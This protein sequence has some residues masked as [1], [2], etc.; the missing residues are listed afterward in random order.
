[1]PFI[2]ATGRNIATMAM[3]VAITARPISD[4]A[5]E[6]ASRGAI[7]SSICLWIFSMTIMASSISMPTERERASM[8]MLLKVKLKAFMIANVAIMDVGMARAL[9]SVILTLFRNSNTASAAKKPP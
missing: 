1:M 4:V 5:K 2:N 6:A 7:P 8:L 3:V 9:I